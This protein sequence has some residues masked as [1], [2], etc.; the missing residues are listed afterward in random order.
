MVTIFEKYTVYAVM[1]DGFTQEQIT[2]T[3]PDA[4]NN[5]FQMIPTLKENVK[6][7]VGL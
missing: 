3:S 6:E 7:Q 1:E 5:I 4:A 2:S